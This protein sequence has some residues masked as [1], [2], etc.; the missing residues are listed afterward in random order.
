MWLFQN[1]L[2]V[3][4]QCIMNAINDVGNRVDNSMLND[5]QWLLTFFAMK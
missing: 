4:D 5:G 2:A 3:T 1:A